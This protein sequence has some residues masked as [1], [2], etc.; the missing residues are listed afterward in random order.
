M[1]LVYAGNLGPAQALD[2]VLR[3]VRRL[4]KEGVEIDVD[5]YG[6]GSEEERLRALVGELGLTRVH[7][8][9]RVSPE[10]ALRASAEATGQIVH[11]TPSPLFEMTVPSKLAFCLAAG[12]PVLAGVAGEARDVARESGGAVVFTPGSEEDFARAVRE[13]LGM[14]GDERRAMGA[15]GRRY[16]EENL[17][18]EILCEKYVDMTAA[19]LGEARAEEAAE[20]D[21]PNRQRFP[22]STGL[23]WWA[24]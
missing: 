12:K 15:R 10:E 20:T 9:G 5:F 11:L 7:F 8:K 24:R 1:R 2:V 23:E 21:L 18:P 16:F 4:A 13:L 14:S 22:S 6:A 19:L 3:G 17:K